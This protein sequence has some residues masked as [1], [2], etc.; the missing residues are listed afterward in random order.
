MGSNGR[1][2]G[3]SRLVGAHPGHERTV[4]I[5]RQCLMLEED[6]AVWET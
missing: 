5:T 2:P 1:W 4:A 3:I 6:F